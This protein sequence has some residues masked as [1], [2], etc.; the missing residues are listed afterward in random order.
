MSIKGHLLLFGL[1]SSTI[2]SAFLLA[3]PSA[4]A[5]C[6]TVDGITHCSTSANASVTVPAACTMTATYNTPHTATINPGTN[7]TDIGQ[8]T[9]KVICN[10][11]GGYSVYA[12]GYTGE[13]IGATNSNKLVN[14]TDSAKTISTGTATS[15]NTSNWSMKLAAVSGTF[16][17]TI[18]N[19]FSSYHTVPLTYTKVATYPSSTMTPSTP[20]TAT[21]GSSLTTTYSAFITSTQSPGTYAGKVKYTMVHPADKVPVAPLAESDCTA[22]KICY[23]PN[24]ND[25]EGSMDSISSTKIASAATAGVQT[26]VS[27]NGTPTLI[28]PNYS[29]AGYGFA[30]WSTD[31]EADSSSIIYGPNE[32]ITTSTS[33]TGD[34]DVSSHGLILYPVWIASTGNLQNWSG[35]SSLTQASYNST[36]GELS[37][38]LSSMTALMDQRDG[39]VYTVA[40]LTDGKCWMT[41]NLRLEAEDSADSTLAQGFAGVFNGLDSSENS[42]FENTTNATPNNK[43]SSSNITGSYPGYRIPRYNNNNIN[44]SLGASYNGTGSGTYYQW[45]SY[46]NYYTWA[47]ALANTNYYDDATST[48]DGKTSES[49]NTSLC[50]TGWRLPY[51]RN[52]G[53]GITAG[54]FSNLDTSMGGTGANY[55][56]NPVTSFSMSEYWRQFPNNFIY[57]GTID[58]ASTLLRGTSGSYW[59]STSI[60]GFQAY[61]LVF[62]YGYVNPG[63]QGQLKNRGLSI[64]CVLGS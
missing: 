15:G 55:S 60:H 39:N 48:V 19:G 56:I 52:E 23:A 6:T 27:S 9:L 53:N 12:V 63:T 18:E 3:S 33:G 1:I 38:T 47:A 62:D 35:C 59:S 32:T 24:A 61:H 4:S 30:G 37:A 20:A 5:T 36:T 43:Y 42:N 41:E 46:G 22:N 11:A 28:A 10:D 8:T 54:G 7:T 13:E 14:S 45:Y 51:G 58:T 17:P 21:T 44:R 29:R 57:A 34:A 31:F 2:I 25:I 50:P 40:K 16:A 26:S 49:A 64:R